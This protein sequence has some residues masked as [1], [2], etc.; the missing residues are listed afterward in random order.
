MKVTS[1]TAWLKSN[2]AGPHMAV[3][4]SGSVVKFR[5]P[6]AGQLLKSGA[7]PT[8]LREAAIVFTSHPDGADELMREL[9]I[10]AALRGPGQDTLTNVIS[11][12]Q[13]LGDILVA[14]MILEPEVTVEDVAE[15]RVPELDVRML[16]EFAERIRNTD[17]AGN[18]LPITTMDEWATFR[19][20]S[21]GDRKPDD[22]NGDGP[23]VGDAVPDA[24]AG[25][26]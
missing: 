11:A 21:A 18:V 20:Q 14:S 4:P 1:R 3:L 13:D 2:D 5:I 19:R 17:A 10:Q 23:A 26:V 24:D 25:E 12:G 22:G 9:V 16:R 7:I 15:G 8:N 6:D